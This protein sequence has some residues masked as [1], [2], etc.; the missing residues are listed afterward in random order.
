MC[1]ISTPF[2]DPNSNYVKRSAEDD[3]V[4][5]D[6]AQ[7]LNDGTAVRM[8]DCEAFKCEVVSMGKQAYEIVSEALEDLRRRK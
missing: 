1:Y 5:M 2:I 7:E 4:L 3:E 8:E 6:L